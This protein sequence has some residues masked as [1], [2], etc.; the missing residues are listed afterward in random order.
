[1]AVL[2]R[3]FDHSLYRPECI[4]ETATAYDGLMNV[5]VTASSNA[6]AVQFE[7]QEDDLTMLVDAFSNHALFLSIG[8]FREGVGA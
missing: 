4:T 7:G 5:V 3:I 6:T 8:A 1:M 2:E